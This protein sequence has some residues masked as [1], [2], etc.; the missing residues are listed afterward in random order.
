[1]NI[2]N[3][4]KK[5]RKEKIQKIQK[6]IEKKSINISLIKI[7]QNTQKIVKDWL[8]KIKKFNSVFSTDKGFIGKEN[9]IREEKFKIECLRIQLEIFKV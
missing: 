4:E 3:Q 7:Y 8:R 6:R 1:M 2:K 5:E 9:S